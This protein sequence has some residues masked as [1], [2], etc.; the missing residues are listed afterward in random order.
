MR[1][2]IDYQQMLQLLSVVLHCPICNQKYSAE[3]TN[4]IDSHPD[5]ERYESSLIYLHAECE[6]CRSSV[7][8]NVNL[9]GSEVF[10]VGMVTDLTARDAKKFQSLGPI[11]VDEVI[12]F[13]EF[14]Q[15]FEGD[16]AKALK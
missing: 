2:K 6:R 1:K 7:V 8:F 3:Q 4:L 14:L 11:T 5:P 10:S 16:L 15:N 9:D 13:H 12:D